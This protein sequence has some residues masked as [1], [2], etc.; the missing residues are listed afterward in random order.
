MHQWKTYK[1]ILVSHLENLPVG[2]GI[3]LGGSTVDDSL[4]MLANVM[5]GILD[6]LERLDNLFL[7]K[8]HGSQDQSSDMVQNIKVNALSQDIED[9]LGL[10]ERR[11][12]K[13]QAQRVVSSGILS[14][15]MS[16]L[17]FSHG[18]MAKEL[19]SLVASTAK[20]QIILSSLRLQA[21]QL[22]KLEDS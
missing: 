22:N 7:A 3:R 8:S 2:D 16:R 9:A 20:K 21:S 18:K 15:D 19:H 4:G 1:Q 5:Q 11:V 12:L 6:N 14:E 10:Q 13:D 17:V